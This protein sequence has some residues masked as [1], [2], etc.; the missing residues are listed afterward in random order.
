MPRDVTE[1][2]Q[3]NNEPNAVLAK[4]IA[5]Q[6]NKSLWPQLRCEAYSLGP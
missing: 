2:Q 5:L 1:F 4:F 6:A 3:L